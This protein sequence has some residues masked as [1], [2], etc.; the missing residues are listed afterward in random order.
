MS[1]RLCVCSSVCLFVCVSVCLFVC[2]SVRLILLCLFVCS[3]CSS[4]IHVKCSGL[5]VYCIIRHDVTSASYLCKSCVKNEADQQYDA[6]FYMITTLL[7]TNNVDDDAAGSE[8]L[9]Q[10]T[11]DTSEETRPEEEE[12]QSQS[13]NPSN[14]TNVEPSRQQEQLQTNYANN[15]INDAA[16]GVYKEFLKKKC[17]HGKSG[18]IGGTCPF[19]HPKICHWFLRSRNKKD[20]CK[21]GGDCTFY[22]PK[23]CWQYSKR[24]S[25]SRQECSFYHAKGNRSNVPKNINAAHPRPNVNSNMAVNNNR[26]VTIYANAV[27][28]GNLAPQVAVQRDVAAPDF[29][30]LQTQM[31]EQMRQTQQLLQMLM[32]KDGRFDNARQTLCQ[33]GSRS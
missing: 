14:T 11:E 3:F 28:R 2:V 27:G 17:P 30:V 6:S 31:Q 23:M 24:G 4:Y 13:G 33:C 1:V 32:M 20:G 10:S 12:T 25:C 26:R 7:S 5:P 15:S 21:K 8:N 29:L 19:S 18:K 9:A 22:H 16:R